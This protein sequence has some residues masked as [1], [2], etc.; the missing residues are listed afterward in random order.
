MG[1]KTELS[2]WHSHITQAQKLYYSNSTSNLSQTAA[3][4]SLSSPAVTSNADTSKLKRSSGYWG[5]ISTSAPAGTCRGL[6]PGGQSIS[7]RSSYISIT[8]P[9][10]RFQINQNA[11]N[12][13]DYDCARSIQAIEVSQHN[14][15]ND[16]DISSLSDYMEYDDEAYESVSDDSELKKSKSDPSLSNAS[17]ATPQHNTKTTHTPIRCESKSTINRDQSLISMAEII[18]QQNESTPILTPPSTR[19]VSPLDK[20]TVLIEADLQLKN[21]HD[22]NF[23]KLPT[24]HICRQIDDYS[25]S[26]HESIKT[27][28]DLSIQMTETRKQLNLLALEDSQRIIRIS[29]L[30]Q[31]SQKLLEELATWRKS[32]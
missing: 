17:S 25:K 18:E 15:K 32:F 5:K 26:F 14:F 23:I 27:L 29:S 4:S 31:K 28:N 7:L 21:F 1:S 6:I 16:D 9:S 22:Q 11:S 8:D 12:H 20:G 13:F 19:S 30:T 10:K 3:N 24:F 2:V